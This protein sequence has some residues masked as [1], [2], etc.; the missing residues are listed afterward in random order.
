MNDSSHA[1]PALAVADVTMQFGGLTALSDVTLDVS[2]GTRYGI[3]GPNGAGKTTLFNVITG[4]ISPT[5]GNVLLFGDDIT[6]IP[7]HQ[8]VAQG[9]VRT[10]QITTLFPELSVREN[11]LMASLVQTNAHRVFWRPATHNPEAVRLAEEQL[12][13]LGLFHLAHNSVRDLSYGE[14]RLLEVALALASQPR[15]LLLDEPTAGLSSAEIE[16]V[17]RLVNN[18]PQD[19]TVVM[20][21]HDL[22][23]IFD[24]VEQLSVLHFGAVIAEGY[25]QDVRHDERVKEVYF[26]DA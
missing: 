25:V 3:I 13:E 14:Q 24:V 4:F 20:I 26:G 5:E 16:A 1:T 17:V 11:V 19:L 22:D 6:A 12:Q 21:E 10:F 2:S 8:R 9:L 18:L 15:V 7:P 23:V